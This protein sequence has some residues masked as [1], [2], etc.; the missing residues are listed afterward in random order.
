MPGDDFQALHEIIERAR[1]RLDGNIWDFIVGGAESEMTLRRNRLALDSIAFRPRV[2]RDVN[3]IDAGTSF[4][5]AGFGFGSGLVTLATGLA[6]A[7]GFFTAGFF[8]AAGFA[9]AMDFFAAGPAGFFVTAFFD[10]GRAG[11]RPALLAVVFGLAGDLRAGFLAMVILC[12]AA[13]AESGRAR[14]E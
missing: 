8:F 3:G 13:R 12:S 2:L 4:F 6:F 11:L 1:A 10:A 7:T 9:F 5:G 14:A